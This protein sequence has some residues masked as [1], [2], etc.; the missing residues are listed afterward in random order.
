MIAPMGLLTVFEV[1]EEKTDRGLPVLWSVDASSV[2][3]SLPQT[4]LT[5]RGKL[6]EVAISMMLVDSAKETQEDG[7]PKK[8]MS[9]SPS[10]ALPKY[11]RRALR[12]QALQK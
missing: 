8:V 9:G 5:K 11:M 6:G 7:T 2:V 12:T 10:K 1:A 4:N 3:L